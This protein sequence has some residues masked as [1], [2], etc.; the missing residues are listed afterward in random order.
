MNFEI[1]TFVVSRQSKRTTFSMNWDHV[2]N[3]H[4]IVIYI[5]ASTLVLRK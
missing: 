1:G 3:I 4:S 5:K 2:V